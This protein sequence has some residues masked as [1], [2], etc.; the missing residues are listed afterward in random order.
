MS[1]RVTLDHT[2]AGNDFNV[3]ADGPMDEAVRRYA[4]KRPLKLFFRDPAALG[5]WWDACVRVH[6]VGGNESETYW[7][8]NETYWPPNEPS[9]F[10]QLKADGS[11]YED[12]TPDHELT[13][14]DYGRVAP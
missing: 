12:V 2:R 3:P 10:Y 7:P 11:G 1:W 5:A 9:A 4:F 14:A 13:A 6:P 8:P